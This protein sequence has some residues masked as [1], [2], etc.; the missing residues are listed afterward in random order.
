MLMIKNCINLK[1]VVINDKSLDTVAT[2]LKSLT[3]T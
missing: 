3:V 2:C 1:H